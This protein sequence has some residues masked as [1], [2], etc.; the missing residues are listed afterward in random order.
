ML[1][2]TGEVEIDCIA[3]AQYRRFHNWALVPCC[4]SCSSPKRFEIPGHIKRSDDLFVGA[5][6][7]VGINT[8]S[9]Y[10]PQRPFVGGLWPAVVYL[11]VQ[12]A[13]KLPSYFERLAPKKSADVKTVSNRS[14]L[15]RNNLDHSPSYFCLSSTRHV[16]EGTNLR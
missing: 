4:Q 9:A 3:S 8:K 12:V 14:S 10:Q 5:N 1:N 15:C 7:Q 16:N 2:T 6:L 11:N 13:V